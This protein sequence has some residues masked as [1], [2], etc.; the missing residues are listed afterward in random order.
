MIY[1]RYKQTYALFETNL[2][3][4]F[5]P[6]HSESADV[7]RC[8]WRIRFLCSCTPLTLAVGVRKFRRVCG[9]FCVLSREIP[10]AAI[11]QAAGT[12]GCAVRIS[13]E[14]FAK[15]LRIRCLCLFTVNFLF[16]IKLYFFGLPD[17]EAN[18]VRF[19]RAEAR[20]LYARSAHDAAACLTAARQNP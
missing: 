11:R 2:A 6:Y 16:V 20:I 1:Y 4:H 17:I 7:T 14:I 13:R 10:L 18:A 19:P 8:P 3:H 9:I 15:S 12:C 5:P